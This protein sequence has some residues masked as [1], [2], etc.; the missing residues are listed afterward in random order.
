MDERLVLLGVLV[1]VCGCTAVLPV[2]THVH[3][4]FEYEYSFK[5]PYLTNAKE[6]VPF[7]SHGGSRSS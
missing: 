4:K 2:M 3:S 7:W 5:G 1:C 6:E